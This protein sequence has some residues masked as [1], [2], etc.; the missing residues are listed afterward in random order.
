MPE[1][2]DN[3]NLDQLI[4]LKRKEK[5]SEEF[6]EGFQK[7][8]RQRQLQ[9]LIEKEEAWFVSLR[10]VFA[11][12]GIWAPLSGLAILVLLLVV[13]FRHPSHRSNPILETVALAGQTNLQPETIAQVALDLPVVKIIGQ[14]AEAEPEAD[15]SAPASFVMDLIPNEEPESITYT[16]EFPTSTIPAE[17]R[18]VGALVSYTVANDLKVFGMAR[19]K[20]I[21]F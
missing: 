12:A 18:P 9:T 14:S 6:W 8:F 10:R 1:N 4:D 19:P 17:N 11:R 13:N 2:P 3:I 15:D 20:S 16:R 21:G 5:P 7:E